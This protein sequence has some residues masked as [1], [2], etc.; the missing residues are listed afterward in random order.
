MFFEISSNWPT[1]FPGPSPMV[2]GWIPFAMAGAGILM[3]VGILKRM[4]GA[5]PVQDSDSIQI[6]SYQFEE[7]QTRTF[8]Y[9]PTSSPDIPKFCPK[10]ETVFEY[11]QLQWTGP[12]K[13]LCPGCS[14]TILAEKREY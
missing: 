3:L 8:D 10:C 7:R 5:R 13:F 14:T 9:H 4:G 1:T 11:E 12:L 6:V 2:V